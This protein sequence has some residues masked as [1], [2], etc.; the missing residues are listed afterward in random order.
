[1]A[2]AASSC[3]RNRVTYIGD[4]LPPSTEVDIYFD[5]ADIERT[6]RV[7]GRATGVV[8]EGGDTDRLN[9]K[10]LQTAREKGA[11]GVIFGQMVRRQSGSTSGNIN[12]FRWIWDFLVGVGGTRSQASFEYEVRADFIKYRDAG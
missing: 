8:S 7:M 2:V 4:S 9:E 12:V 5:V 10:F 6:Y 1:V 3:G 11:D